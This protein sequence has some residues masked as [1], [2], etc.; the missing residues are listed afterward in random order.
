LTFAVPVPEPA[1]GVM[2][3]VG[4]LGMAALFRQPRFGK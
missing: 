2:I 4:L 3:M 1:S